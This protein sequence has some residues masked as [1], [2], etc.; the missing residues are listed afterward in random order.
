MILPGGK[1]DAV[2]TSRRDK[3]IKT[4]IAQRPPDVYFV[5]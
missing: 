5:L 1:E 3:E 4:G 2:A